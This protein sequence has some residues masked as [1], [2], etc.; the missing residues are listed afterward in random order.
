MNYHNVHPA[1][2]VLNAIMIVSTVPYGGHYLVDVLAGAVIAVM[3][4]VAVRA[5]G[6]SPA[7]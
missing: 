2:V 4:I 5:I 7:E 3:S 1:L 6:G